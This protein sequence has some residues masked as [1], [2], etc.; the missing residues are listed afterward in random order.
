MKAGV[1]LARLGAFTLI[2][3]LLASAGTAEAQLWRRAPRAFRV[4]VWAIMSW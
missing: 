1:H 4:R 2:V 3:A